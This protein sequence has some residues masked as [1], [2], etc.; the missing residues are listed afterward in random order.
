MCRNDELSWLFTNRFRATRYM[1]VKRMEITEILRRI[2][3]FSA[4]KIKSSESF[5]KLPTKLTVEVNSSVRH[6]IVTNI[7]K[8]SIKGHE[9]VYVWDYLYVSET[10]KLFQNARR[11]KKG[12]YPSNHGPPKTQFTVSKPWMF[13]GR[14]DYYKQDQ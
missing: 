5:K 2:W 12:G 7:P 6:I 9:H 4:N 10:W 14:C 11:W 8:Y 13:I 3:L 1:K